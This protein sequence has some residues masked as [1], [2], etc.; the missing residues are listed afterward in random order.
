MAWHDSAKTMT[1]V[2]V[3]KK[4][5]YEVIRGATASHCG[6][7]A[8][9]AEKR[10][11]KSKDKR[12]AISIPHATG[13]WF[14]LQ[15]G[16]TGDCVDFVAYEL[17]DRR[18]RELDDADRPKVRE[19]FEPGSSDKPYV[20]STTPRRKPLVLP[21]AFENASNEY[22]PV[23]DVEDFWE[24]CCVDACE[25]RE[26][27]EYLHSRRILD[28]VEEFSLTGVARA[29]TPGALPAW[30][31][32]SPGRTWVDTKHRVI[33]PLFDHHGA[34]RSVVARSVEPEPRIKSSGPAAARRGL[35]M[36]GH[37]AQQILKYG[38]DHRFHALKRLQ[39]VIHEGEIDFM[40][41][42]H[43]DRTEYVGSTINRHVAVFGI[44]AG[45]WARDVADRIPSGSMVHLRVHKDAQGEKYADQIE[46]SLGDR[47]RVERQLIEND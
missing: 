25:D 44:Q 37:A 47:V 46:E 23:A 26:V 2:E 19:W 40:R 11:T 36:A 22:L 7:A 12:G 42:V 28:G 9:G 39:V 29:L 10:H 8:C 45:S 3:A 33:V 41:H 30:A 38:Q 32:M 4:L 13:A 43:L 1:T 24:V 31:S 5:G 16:A 17:C 20:P 14:C 15:C 6:C 21:P 27:R 34:M 18:Y 35:V